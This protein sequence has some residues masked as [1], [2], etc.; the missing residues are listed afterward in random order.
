MASAG[1][2]LRGNELVE[3][4]ASLLVAKERHVVPVEDAKELVPADAL[5]A[6][7]ATAAGRI[8]DLEQ[9]VMSLDPVRAERLLSDLFGLRHDLQMLRTNAAQ[10]QE[11]YTYVI[12][13]LSTRDDLMRLDLR[14]ASEMRQGF[15]HL[16]NTI[17]LER[18][19]LQEV[20]D[21]FQTRVSTELNRFV[22]KITAF[23]TI[24][25]AWTVIAGIYGM[26]FEF[27]PE[28]QWR[29]GYPGVLLT[30]ALVGI[31]FAVLFRRRGWL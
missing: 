15:A 3:A 25:I 4:A 24:A 11:L 20:I 17:D 1:C 23:G 7:V 21:L 14:R 6:L 13:Q 29:Y 28:L 10:T 16:Q 8:A 19:Y 22:R 2:R 30:M 26:N 9:R 5:E 31:V 18:D 27:M 12:E